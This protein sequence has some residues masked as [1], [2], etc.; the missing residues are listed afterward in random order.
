MKLR[1]AREGELDGFMRAMAFAFSERYRSEEL[2][3]AEA[4]LP[5]ERTVGWHEDGEWVGTAAAI[6]FGLTVPGGAQVPAAGVTAVGVLPTHRRRGLLTGMMG[7]LLEQAREC[8]EPVAILFAAESPIYGR[9]GFGAATL[10]RSVRLAR[11]Y[12]RFR[13]D[14]PAPGG[15]LV[16]SAADATAAPR[17]AAVYAR[18]QAQRPGA[19]ARDVA[20]F[21]HATL[22]REHD[23]PAP[24]RLVVNEGDDGDEGYALY[25]V[26]EG[27]DELVDLPDGS[28]TVL[29]LVA[30]TP[31]AATA[32]WR[33]LLDVDLVERVVASRRPADEP[34]PHLLA[35][36]GRLEQRVVEGLYVA[37]LDAPAALRARR[38]G[39]EDAIV[40]EVSGSGS[41][42]LA[43]GP[44][45]A[46]CSPTSA[47]A[48]I[49]LPAEALGALYLGG[50][51][52]A[53]MAAAGRIEERSAGALPRLAAM[54][55]APVAPWCPFTF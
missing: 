48:D 50:V 6:P 36:T 20:Y 34:L 7:A 21:T 39:A 27:W 11:P 33:Y 17:L 46:D 12:T 25:R 49:A 19:P 31:A 3:D 35:D 14:V 45:G 47:P 2:A 52:P 10:D 44:D 1:A 30:L 4:L 37:L 18:E 41:L 29:E 53:A 55:A 32:L 43:G 15:H 9:F 40:L 22:A 23:E 5:L 26:V 24:R 54:L 51:S 13:P 8:Q 28:L 38:Y 16:A 42:Q